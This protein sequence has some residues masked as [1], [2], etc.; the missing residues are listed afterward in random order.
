MTDH[1]ISLYVSATKPGYIEH[2]LTVS[3]DEV[4]VDLEDSVPSDEKDSARDVAREFL[5]AHP[6]VENLIIRVNQP[7]GTALYDDLSTLVPLGL[8]AI[9][10][11]GARRFED[12]SRFFSWTKEFVD[13]SSVRLEL[14]IEN[15]EIFSDITRIVETFP[16]VKALTFGGGDYLA[17]IKS[18]SLESLWEAKRQLVA[19]ARE[20]GLPAYDTVFSDYHSRDLV[21]GD[22]LRAASL[23]FHGKSVIHPAQIPVT[24][25]AFSDACSS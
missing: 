13:Q 7:R 14:M 10:L 20:C 15:R 23:G 21:F 5:R 9:R 17:D 8:R 4:V 12:V 19:V 3:V 16:Q 6:G 1:V 24:R 11:P 2:A 22:A 18:E 25:E